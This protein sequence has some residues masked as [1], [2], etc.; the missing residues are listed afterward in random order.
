MKKANKQDIG[1]LNYDRWTSDTQLTHTHTKCGS[2]P[3][4]GNKSQVVRLN[5][6]TCQTVSLNLPTWVVSEE[7]K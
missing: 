5:F 4:L 3:S 7:A 1:L 6:Y 2:T